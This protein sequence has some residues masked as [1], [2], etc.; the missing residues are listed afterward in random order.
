LPTYPPGF[1]WDKDSV[2]SF[3]FASPLTVNGKQYVWSSTSGLSSLQYG[4]ITVTTSG[5]VVGNY[6]ITNAITFAKEGVGSDFTG[7]VIIIDD[8]SYTLPQ[9]FYWSLGTTHTFAF[10]SPL[11]VTPNAKRYV[12]TSTTG[13]SNQQSGSITV[14][15]YGSIVGHYKTQ[16]FLDLVTSPPSVV[17]LSGAGWYDANTYA[18]ITASPYVDIVSGS[19]RYRFNG[20]TTA[21][22]SEIVNPSLPSTQVLVDNAKIVTANYVLQYYF[23]VSTPCHSPPC[24]SPIPPLPGEWF[25]AGTPITA[26]VASPWSGSAGTQY[27][28][29]GWTGTGDVPPSG[30]GNSVTFT[31]TQPSSITWNWQTQYY[32]T[33][34]TNPSG[35]ALIPGEGWYDVSASITLTAP[36]VAGYDFVYWDV[37]GAHQGTGVA[38][39]TVTMNAPHTATAHYKS[40]AAPVGGYTVSLGQP[41][42]APLVGYALILAI[43]SA[44]LTLIKRKRK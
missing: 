28:C 21:V 5:N 20:W 24:G 29:I 13:L 6:I 12:W 16:Y 43:F 33:V 44:A 10:Q 7:T 39:I 34:R 41:V 17:P 4:T 15:T 14:S 36:S 2:H 35:M 37:D 18:T 23:A 9:S 25:D 3:T 26:S 40:I 30:T 19:S 31:I 27:V 22:M 42:I 1:W 38:T 32:S 11:V 8:I